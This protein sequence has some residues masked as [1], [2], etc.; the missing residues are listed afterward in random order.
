MPHTQQLVLLAVLTKLGTSA[1]IDLG[2]APTGGVIGNNFVA[3]RD[4]AIRSALQRL[5]DAKTIEIVS[6]DID[7]KS[8][9]V[10]TLIRWRDLST[11][12]IGETIL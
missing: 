2:L 10:F 5:V 12:Q 7:A 6:I 11:K 1:D 4:A 9:P 8:R 3:H